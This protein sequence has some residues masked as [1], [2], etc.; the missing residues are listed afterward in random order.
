L[1]EPI[2]A[3]APMVLAADVN[4]EGLTEGKQEA[5]ADL[6]DGVSVQIF[7][8][9]SPLEQKL[10]VFDHGQQL[11]ELESGKFIQAISF[12]FGPSRYWIISAYSGGAH[13]CAVYYF[14]CRPEGDRPLRS[15]GET[16][17]HNGGPLK[18]KGAT[19]FIRGQMYFAGLDNRFD[20][21]HESHAGSRLVNVPRVFYRLSPDSLHLDNAAFKEIYL[22][23][24]VDADVEIL[25]EA[26]N[27]LAKPEAILAPGLGSGYESLHFSDNLGQ[28]LITRTI[29]FLYAREDARAW[30]SLEEDVKKYYRTTKWVPELQREI[31][32]MMSEK[33]Y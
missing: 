14:F 33:A 4:L 30:Q 15:L 19:L 16:P 29:L 12:E 11:K 25:K 32:Q 7:Q 13:C 9:K 8:G 17:G 18:L 5:S 24:A 26:S 20:Y 27:R 31:Q 21:F 23:E 28:L 1:A 22:K 6:S 10:V 3:A 2:Q